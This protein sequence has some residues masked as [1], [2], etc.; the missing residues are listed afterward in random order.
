[1]IYGIGTDVVE[2]ARIAKALKK[3]GDAF[4]KKILS[5]EEFVIFKKNNL[6]ENF[7][8]KRFAAKEAF[9]KAMGTGFRGGV[10]IKSIIVTNNELGRPDIKL[11]NNMSLM[12]QEKK[13]KSCHLSISDEKNI[14]VA[15][16]VLEKE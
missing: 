3:F 9:A 4:A 16:V 8:A 2:V 11:E 5:Q 15:F 7:L 12:L 6:K 14:A 13:I 1:M 10:N